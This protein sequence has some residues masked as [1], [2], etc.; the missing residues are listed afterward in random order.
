VPYLTIDTHLPLLVV[1]RV[2]A[3]DAASVSSM[4]AWTGR[5]FAASEQKLGFVYDAGE[6]PGGLP[7]APARKAGGEWLGRNQTLMREKCAGLDF[8]FASPVSRGALTAVFWIAQPSVPWTMHA[9]LRAAVV[10]AIAR[11]GDTTLVVD[12]VIRDLARRPSR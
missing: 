8:A 10:S 9:S 5:H 7:D 3:A 11:V 1:R 6:T 4:L 2:G 12:D